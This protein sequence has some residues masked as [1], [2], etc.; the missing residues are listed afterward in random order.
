MEKTISKSVECLI[1][2][3][4]GKVKIDSKT[5]KILT[6]NFEYFGKINANSLKMSKDF[7][8]VLFDKNGKM[9]K[10]KKGYMKT[11]EVKNPDYDPKA[12]KELIEYWECKKCYNKGNK[13]S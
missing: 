10:D 12:K 1:C 13:S 11:K 5:R 6:H 3:K 9:L 4:K 7:Y 8:E 2:G